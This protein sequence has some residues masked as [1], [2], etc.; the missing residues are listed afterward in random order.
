MTA[1]ELESLFQT[2]LAQ[3]AVKL[4]YQLQQPGETNR[5]TISVMSHN[6]EHGSFDQLLDSL[7]SYTYSRSVGT[8]NWPI[9]TKDT[10]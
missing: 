6:T 7:E 3:G 5:L 10:A 8:D 2:Q 1:Q 4:Y 9:F